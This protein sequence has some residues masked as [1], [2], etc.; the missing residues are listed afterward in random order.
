MKKRH[1]ARFFGNLYWLFVQGRSNLKQSFEDVYAET[2]NNATF[3]KIY[4]DVF[5]PEYAEEANPCGFSTK[6]DI[7]NIKRHIDLKPGEKL[8]DVACGRG[9]NG[10]VVAR[11]L[12]AQ[13]VGV[14]LSTEAVKAAKRRID[15]FGMRERAEFLAADMRE[16]PFSDAEFDAALCVDTLYMVPDKRAGLQQIRRVLKPGRPFVI[17]T[18]EMD[19]PFAVKD[20]HPLLNECGFRVSHYEMIEGWYQRQ[21]GIYEGILANQKTLISEMGKR[22]AAFWINGANIELPKLDKMRRVFIV[23][24]REA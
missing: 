13:L 16:L 1:F 15:D 18:W 12:G 3:Q 8:I 10:L 24:Q 23:A 22:T 9:G 11:D 17:I 19:V 4:R 2:S 5:G 7:E 14:D 6:S 20:Y 21:K